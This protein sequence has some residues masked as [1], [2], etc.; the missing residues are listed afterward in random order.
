MSE[1]KWTVV[2]RERD[3]NRRRAM[4][5]S[6]YHALRIRQLGSPLEP[7]VWFGQRL[8]EVAGRRGTMVVSGNSEDSREGT[9]PDW[10]D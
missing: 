3:A 1:W 10:H 7:S 8:F 6:P 4:M 2:E 5:G 9:L